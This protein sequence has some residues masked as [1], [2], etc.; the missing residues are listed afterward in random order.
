MTQ[1]SFTLTDVVI[2]FKVIKIN[3]GSPPVTFSAF[4]YV[5]NS[6]G[7]PPRPWGF[8]NL[9]AVNFGRIPEE[10]HDHIGLFQGIQT[11]NNI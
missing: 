1:I 6:I 11:S 3:T 4:N 7:D 10:V 9:G 2:Y 8:I 5:I